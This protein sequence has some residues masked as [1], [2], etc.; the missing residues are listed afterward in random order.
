MC[1]NRLNQ[2]GERVY[3]QPLYTAIL[4]PIP[5]FMFPW[6]P[7][8]DYLHKLETIVLGNTEGGAAYLNFVESYYSFG[9]FGVIIWAWFLGWFARRFWDNYQNNRQSIGAIIAL[10]VFSG[11]CYVFISRGYLAASLTSLLI[12]LYL[13]FI[14]ISWYCKF[15]YR[16]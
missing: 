13:P 1:I 7:D 16:K 11:L 2:S 14:F 3:F 12:A 10:G 15:F 6:K 9:W 8:A 5:R 4:M